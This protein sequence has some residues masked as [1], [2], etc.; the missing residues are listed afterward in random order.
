[1]TK[2]KMSSALH[3]L[4]AIASE[5]FDFILIGCIAMGIIFKL[6]WV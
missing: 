2:E 1:M 5:N 4:H 3:I 6:A